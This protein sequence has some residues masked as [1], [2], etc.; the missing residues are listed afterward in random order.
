MT[1]IT[2]EMLLQQREVTENEMRSAQDIVLKCEGALLTID[3]LI[4]QLGMEVMPA[5]RMEDICHTR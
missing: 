3:H 2:R 1:E 4:S 5:E